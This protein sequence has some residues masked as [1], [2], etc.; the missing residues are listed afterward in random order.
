MQTVLFTPPAEHHA[1]SP[2]EAK[3]VAA[4]YALHRVKS[5]MPLYRVL[6]PEHRDYWKHYDTLKTASN[7]WQYDPDPFNAH[8]PISVSK[9]SRSLPTKRACSFSGSYAK[10]TFS[11]RSSERNRK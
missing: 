8:A 9:K 1:P 2:I 5:D 3:H 6:P 10:R 4:T 11:R 7:K